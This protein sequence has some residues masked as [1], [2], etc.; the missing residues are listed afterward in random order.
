MEFRMRLPRKT[1]LGFVNLSILDCER[2][3][4]RGSL[5]AC[6]TQMRRDCAKGRG[7]EELACGS[8]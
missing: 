2:M 4:E 8:F 3:N 7:R 6:S 1:K 5:V